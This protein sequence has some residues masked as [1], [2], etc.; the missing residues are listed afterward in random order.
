MSERYRSAAAG[1]V[2]VLHQGA[3]LLQSMQPAV[4]GSFVVPGAFVGGP[5]GPTLLSRIASTVP[6]F[7]GS[8]S[9]AQRSERKASGLK[10]PPKKAL[11][12]TTF[13]KKASWLAWLFA[14][15]SGA[16]FAQQPRVLDDFES[17]QP[18]TVVTSNQ[19]TASLRP[20]DGSQGRALCLDYDFN[21]VSGYAGL[22]RA[23]PLDYPDN[24]RF[25]FQ[26]RGDSP[27]NDLQFKLVDASGD[28][29][30]WVNR[31]KY[32]YPKQWT[33]VVYKQRHI[34]RAWGPAPDPVLRKSAKLEF[35]VYNSAGG[36]G[37]VCFDQLSFQALPKDD[38]APLTGQAGAT[39]SAQGSRAGF[40]V[41]GDPASAW[42][43][44][45]GARPQPSLSLDLGRA[46]EFGG[47][48]L[49]WADDGF[50]S[51]YRIDLSH[52]GRRWR[53]AATVEAGNG[54]EDLI[55]LP[56]SEARFI[57]VTPLRGPGPGFGL[58]ELSVQPLA[59]A[60]TPNDFVKQLA[61]RAPRGD[62]PRGFSGE[63]PYWTVVGSDGGLQ[64][65]LI[66]EDGAVEAYKAGFSVEPFLLD[67]PARPDGPPRA[68]ALTTWADVKTRQSL[69]D[70]YLPIPSVDWD[71]GDL[72]L[73][74]T[75]FSPV[76]EGAEQMVVRYQVRNVS[77]QPRDT[78]LALAIRPLQ[79]NPPTQFLSTTGGVSAID[80]LSIDLDGG[81]VSVNGNPGLHSLTPVATAFATPL[82]S[83]EAVGHLRSGRPWPGQTRARDPGGLA[84]GALLYPL[85][86]APGERRD[87]VV[88]VP[89]DP[90]ASPPSRD[91][92]AAE[93]WQA[94]TAA[95]WRDKLD[96]VK[97]RVPPAGQHVVDT[98]R[99]GLAHMLISREGP[100]LQPG[101][102]SY[103]R[104]WIR[105]GAMIG[106]GLLRM[107]RA[108][109]AEDFL[110]WYAP[111]QFANGKVPC[112]VDDRGSDPVPENDSHGELIF[113]VAEVYRYTRDR[114]LLEAMWPHVQGA[115]RYMDELRLSERTD[116]N[117]ALNPAFYG[118]MPASIS[119]EG[120]S[121]KPMHSYWDNFWALRGYKD[122]VEIAQWLGE[123]AAAQAFTASRD[124]FR[125]D[126][127][128]SIESATRQHG[129][130][131]IPGAAELGDF[132]ATSTT[133]AL[134]PGGEQGLLPATLLHNTFERYWKEFVE[135]R[136]GR[137]EWKDYTPYE[138]RTVGSFVRLGWRER[139]HEALAF[140]FK[141]QQPRGWNQWAEV[142]S[143]TPRKPFF[144]GDLPHAWVESDY[145]RSAL[146]LFA[147]TR[148]VD[149]ALVIAAGLPP[150]WLDG[151]GVSVD[152]LRTPYGELGYRL[153]REG[154]RATLELA[155]G[156]KVPPGGIVLKWPF[157]GT[158]GA[159]RVDGRAR[160]WS[161]DELKIERAPARV[162]VEME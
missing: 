110:R 103:A 66:G 155:G 2:A 17:A 57:R 16:A 49:R 51:D 129:I 13:P 146:D 159:T 144:L 133:I 68:S 83:G 134:A 137:R 120:Y 148:D 152:G 4:A 118:M 119:H 33:P 10:A 34:S 5:S 160:A 90:G 93:A 75:A 15:A 95:L 99:T 140:F 41:D 147:Y 26:I 54:G 22:Q 46:R 53:D 70:G 21:G 127:Y 25:A 154:G 122:A 40:A 77:A 69:Q 115:V 47:L 62:Y 139:A 38:G 142:V 60:A 158:P 98:L 78:T 135:R 45:F 138:L 29:V 97:L 42:R 145:V 48:V 88:F 85:R 162:V 157:A 58:A 59:F 132:D 28:N 111:F 156:V 43:A 56:E 104:A 126:L 84:S 8:R 149:Q 153:R 80:E 72:Q 39:S 65:G 108:D 7:S 32:A 128:R 31:P 79:V 161:G 87:V 71:A 125:D 11:P 124:Q 130:D 36:K 91:P 89:Q 107:G 131:Y 37:S 116:A 52:D 63:Q 61:L 151:E 105:D 64:Q 3:V 136:D 82:Q 86:L 102:R 100:R 114:A 76:F 50:A 24:Y 12:Q 55:A 73:T 123:D 18:W 9:V 67:D 106:E 6:G 44:G 112:C 30:W 23:L 121:A 101:T 109:V 35:T 117:R 150:E 1:I 14:M 113:T 92:A 74:V 19:V 143:R 81:V 96:R 20:V 27:A 94:A 141:D